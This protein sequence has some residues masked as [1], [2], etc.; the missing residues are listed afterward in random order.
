VYSC[1]DGE[2]THN[3]TT[4]LLEGGD[5]FAIE[6][7][8][9][10]ALDQFIATLPEA[11]IELPP[12]PRNGEKEQ[13][14]GDYNESAAT[15]NNLYLLDKKT[16]RVDTSTS[17]VEVCDL[18]SKEGHF[19]HVKRKLQSAS[20]S[21]LF[22]QG[23]VAGELFVRDQAFRAATRNQV[24]EAAFRN[25]IP[26]GTPNTRDYEIVYAIIAKWK[27]RTLKKALPFFSKIN[28]RRHAETLQSMGYKVSYKRINI[29]P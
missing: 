22:G 21:H 7:H 20:L 23:A 14:E 16:V 1:L 4:Y 18:L 3:G 26:D 5:Y 24:T 9:Q 10:R 25:Q 17:P 6:K 19:I 12:S 29:V 2:V 15:S 8:Y 13:T 28:L 27:N 11:N